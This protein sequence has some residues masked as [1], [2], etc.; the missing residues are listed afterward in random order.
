MNSLERNMANDQNGGVGKNRVSC[1]DSAIDK[2]QLMKKIQALSFAKTESELYLDAHPSAE[3]AISY[4]KD[5]VARLG[6]LCEQYEAKYGPITA[7]GVA[8]DRWS[9]VDGAWPWQY[10]AGEDA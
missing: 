8:G 4:Y 5:L 6:A 10:N 3:A 2:A 1:S 9:W 7:S